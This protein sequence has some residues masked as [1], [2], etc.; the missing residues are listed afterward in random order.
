MLVTLRTAC[1]ATAT[2]LV[3]T[4]LP[5]AAAA[6]TQAAPAAEAP[7]IT[8]NI[9]MEYTT[10]EG[11]F[12]QPSGPLKLRVLA[13]DEDH[14]L[15]LFKFKPGYTK[16]DYKKDVNALFGLYRDGGK[17]NAA[18]VRRMQ[19][20]VT[21]L[22]GA[23][24]SL[25]AVATATV[26]LKPGTY[27]LSDNVGP[28]TGRMKKLTITQA[29]TP[30]AA[31]PG[32]VPVVTMTKDLEFGGASKLPATGTIEIRNVVPAGHRWLQAGLLQVL[33]GTK[34]EQVSDLFA[35][36]TGDGGFILAGYVG[37]D[38]LSPGQ[39]QYLTY[40]VEPG[41]YALFCYFPDPDHPGST[42]VADGMVKI[43]E[44]D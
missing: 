27:W 36:R 20:K 12:T 1:V 15:S 39:R 42:Y 34:P 8:A 23:T 11:G 41:T 17:K 35:G 16:K 18:A 37:G 3:A 44:L 9:A 40:S 10:Y 29:R 32:K 24:A 7:M 38:V 2:A 4:V 26:N 13:I 28:R 31:M 30:A 14:L 6:T 5:V 43:V 21:T 25:G 33:P 22:G 19:K